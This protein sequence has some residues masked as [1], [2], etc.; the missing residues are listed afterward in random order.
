MTDRIPFAVISALLALYVPSDLP[1]AGA[2]RPVAQV[3]GP[4]DVNGMLQRALGVKVQLSPGEIQ[5]ILGPHAGTPGWKNPG[6]LFTG[7]LILFQ[8]DPDKYIE[9]PKSINEIKSTLSHCNNSKW[10]NRQRTGVYGDAGTECANLGSWLVNSSGL[11]NAEAET[12]LQRSCALPELRTESDIS[13]G[14]GRSP[15]AMLGDLYRDR[16][17]LDL[18]LAVYLHAPNCNLTIFDTAQDALSEACRQGAVDVYAAEGNSKHEQGLLASLCAQY[19]DRWS[20]D[21]QLYRA[22]GGSVDLNAIEA[23]AEQYHHELNAEIEQANADAVERQ[24][25]H[26]AHVNAVIGALSSLP[27]AND[28]NAIVN[29]ADQETTQM[30]A[31]GAANDAARR[32]ATTQQPPQTNVQQAASDNVAP[33]VQQN[34]QAQQPQLA[35]A[36]SSSNNNSAS[37]PCTAFPA[38]VTASSSAFSQ[39][40]VGGYTY[41]FGTVTFNIP[42]GFHSAGAEIDNLANGGGVGTQQG[43]VISLSNVAGGAANSSAFIVLDTGTYQMRYQASFPTNIPSPFALT[44]LSDKVCAPDPPVSGAG[45]VN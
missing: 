8:A 32:Q 36:P 27:G 2:Q 23:Q 17:E 29:T 41:Y 40:Q 14:D 18:A 15:C 19:G 28:P 38:F 42:A 21:C 44:L 1:A 9:F 7:R 34:Q 35:A 5:V 13:D 24:R 25:E 45:T 4:I 12:A 39:N 37:S 16:G 10:A 6:L 43:V 30:V 26:D 3:S 31:V 22:N 20:D 11:E 33:T